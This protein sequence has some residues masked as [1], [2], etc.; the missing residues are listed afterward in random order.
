[1]ST[2]SVPPP[3]GSSSSIPPAGPRPVAL[4][5]GAPDPERGVL[6]RAARTIGGLGG[7][8]PEDGSADLQRYLGILFERRFVLLGLVRFTRNDLPRGI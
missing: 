2:P 8:R 6:S 5:P 4:V 3:G 1:M 7:Y